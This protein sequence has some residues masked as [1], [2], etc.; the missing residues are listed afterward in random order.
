MRRRPIRLLILAI[1]MLQFICRHLISGEYGPFDRIVELLVLV[2]IAWEVV[3]VPLYRKRVVRRKSREILAFIT[4]GESLQ[5]TIP[6]GGSSDDEVN[7]WVDK[8]K[9]WMLTVHSFLQKDVKQAVAVFN[10]HTIGPHYSLRVP[11]QADPWVHE[12]DARLRNLQSILEK[13]DVY[14]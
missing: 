3:I 1:I 7:V 2:L 8:V 12:L 9:E 13:P 11:P 6:R 5:N 14:F 10:H 4:A